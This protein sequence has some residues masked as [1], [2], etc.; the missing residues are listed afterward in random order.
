MI[1]IKRMKK[2]D[3]KDVARLIGMT[4]EKFNSGDATK[5]GL[6]FY[7]SHHSAGKAEEELWKS[8]N[9]RVSLVALDGNKI[10]GMIKGS[11]G[12]MGNLFVSGKYHGKGV[13]KKLVGDFEKKAKGL[14]IEKIKIRASIYAIP[15]Y[16]ACGYKKSTGIRKIHGIKIQP[17]L[18]VL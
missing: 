11:G 14:G 9:N 16:S 10:I 18:K 2:G 6:A 8:Y 13:G 12:H 15:F 7:L 1:V 17:M 5:K 4:F 3:V